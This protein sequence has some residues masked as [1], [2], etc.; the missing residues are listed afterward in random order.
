VPAASTSQSYLGPRKGVE[1]FQRAKSA[2]IISAMVS[3]AELK[4]TGAGLVPAST[5]WF[6]MNARDARWFHRPSIQVLPPGEP[7]ATY[8]W[9]TEQED[10]LVDTQD[11]EVAYGRFAPSQPTRYRDGLLPD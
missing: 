7:N 11:G 3:E 4:D 8:H 6:V 5:G 9:E 10:F 1:S 2:R